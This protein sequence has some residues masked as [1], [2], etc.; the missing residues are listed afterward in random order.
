MGLYEP[1]VQNA[2]NAD[3]Y[4]YLLLYITCTIDFQCLR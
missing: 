3:N 4:Y 2:Q 1:I